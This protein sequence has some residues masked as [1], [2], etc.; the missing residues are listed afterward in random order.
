MTVI[1]EARPLRLTQALKEV[2][3]GRFASRLG[4]VFLSAV[5]ESTS[6]KRRLDICAH[7]PG[8]V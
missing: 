1:I 2:A 4:L 7:T 8:S 3:E 6:G 5:C